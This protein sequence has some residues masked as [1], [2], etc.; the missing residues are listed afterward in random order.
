G[1]GVDNEE[2][3]M[4]DI[5][6]KRQAALAAIKIGQYALEHNPNVQSNS[7]LQKE[8]NEKI[9]ILKQVLPSGNSVDQRSY[10]QLA[11]R[12]TELIELMETEKLINEEDK[13]L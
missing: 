7:H 5:S 4:V 13:Y 11:N 3:H 8:L 6:Q 12:C 10:Q 9:Q 2:Y 1:G